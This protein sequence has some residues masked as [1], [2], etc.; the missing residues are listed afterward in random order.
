MRRA[1]VFDLW[2]TLVPL[3]KERYRELARELADALDVAVDDFQPAWSATFAAR[4]TGTPTREAIASACASL[5][6]D[7][8]PD[9][10]AQAERRR[11]ATIRSFFGARSEAMEVVPALRARGLKLGLISDAGT[12]TAESWPQSA[13]APEFDAAIFSCRE[14]VTKPAPSLYHKVLQLLGV[15]ATEVLYVGDRSEEL[16]GARAAG[17][18]ALLLDSGELE[19]QAWD[20]RRIKSLKE[21]LDA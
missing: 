14:G 1:V 12:E 10:V 2:G 21:L 9:A 3:P 4:A 16:Y 20:G 18:E 6:V 11:Q 5:G 8:R 19:R 13:L 15:E 17:M 7:P